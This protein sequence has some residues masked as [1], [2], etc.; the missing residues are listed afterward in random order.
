MSQLQCFDKVKKSDIFENIHDY[1]FK[2]ED[3]LT[4]LI[5]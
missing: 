3:L 1:V 4:I 5:T 2:C